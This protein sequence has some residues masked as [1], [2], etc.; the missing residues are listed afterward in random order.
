[1][2]GVPGTILEIAGPTVTI[3][4]GA[5]SRDFMTADMMR[6]SGGEPT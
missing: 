2:E 4:F 3:R 6:L 1:V 5:K